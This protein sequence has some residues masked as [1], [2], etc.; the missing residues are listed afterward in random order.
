MKILTLENQSLDLNTLPDQI[1]EDI[2]FSVLDNSDPANPDFF[3]IPL[4]FL[5]SFSSPSVV[6]DVG[7]YELQMPIDWNIAVGCSDSGNDIEVLPLTS[8][9][10]RG[11]EAFLFNPHTSFKPD[12]TP[13]K[14]INYYNDVKWYFP[15]VRNGQLLSVPIQEKKE[16]LCAY[17]IKDVTRQ[18]EVIKYGELF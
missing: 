2:R 12:F 6:L 9:G 7:G 1:E 13:V 18:T 17:F 15:K 11:F 8:I 5:E 10:D 16:P 3:F 14:V 4:I